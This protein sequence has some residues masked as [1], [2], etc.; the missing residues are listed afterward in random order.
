M[1]IRITHDRN[2]GAAYIYVRGDIPRGAVHVTAKADQSLDHA[3]N[4]DMDVQNRVIG[5]EL[6]GVDSLEVI[7]ITLLRAP[8]EVEEI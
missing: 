8:I 6:L 1:P 3:V 4:L 2:V 5:I 7:D